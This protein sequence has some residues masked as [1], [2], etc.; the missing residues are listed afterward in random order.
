MAVPRTA[1]LRFILEIAMDLLPPWPLL[2]T[3]VAASI[4]LAVTPGPAVLYIVTRSLSQG[5]RAGLASVA[6][7]ALGNLG[8]ALGAAV[9]LAALFAVSAVAFSIVKYAGAAYLVF[10][11]LKALGAATA[12]APV[13]VPPVTDARKIFRDGFVVALLNPKTAIFFAAFLP[14]FMSPAASAL[15]QS[16]GLGALFVLIAAGTDSVYALSASAIAPALAKAR[17]VGAAGRYLTA[18]AF[19][20]LGV[21]TAVSGSRGAK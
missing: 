16:V 3:F 15:T 19:I 11:G 8:N 21:F 18:S 14:Q 13:G 12:T 20:G 2:A 9:G 6:G 1:R 7:V 4:V 10:L 17:R 5:R